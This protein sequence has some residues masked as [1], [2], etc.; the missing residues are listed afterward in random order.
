MRYNTSKFDSKCYVIIKCGMLQVFQVLKIIVQPAQWFEFD[1]PGLR[2]YTI[3]CENF[4]FIC[5]SLSRHLLDMFHFEFN[6]CS[7]MQKKMLE[8][9][10]EFWMPNLFWNLKVFQSSNLAAA[11]SFLKICKKGEKTWQSYLKKCF[12]IAWVKS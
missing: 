2:V 11:V 4:Y 6:C 3:Y 1:M 5:V 9:M 8:K 10:F 7:R 12:N